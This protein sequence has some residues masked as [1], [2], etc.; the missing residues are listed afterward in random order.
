MVG[1]VSGNTNRLSID[2]GSV[3]SSQRH[4]AM[5]KK[6]DANGDGKIDETELGASGKLTG[7]EAAAIMK[8]ADI[9]GDGTIDST[10]NDAFL[11]NVEAQRGAKTPPPGP[12]PSGGGPHGA[13]SGG[14]SG[15]SSEIFDKLDTNKDGKV[16]LEE[17]L[18]ATT[19]ESTSTDVQDLLKSMDTDSDGS[20]SKGELDTF[21]TKLEQE[22]HTLMHSSK[23]YSVDGEGTTDELGQSVDKIV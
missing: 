3:S 5:F 2:L 7:K 15:S 4:A 9:N 6:L 16:S 11:S 13:H 10:E 17:L 19:D 23:T 8:K 18:A 1:S 20:I 21:L 14:S 22:L 12:P